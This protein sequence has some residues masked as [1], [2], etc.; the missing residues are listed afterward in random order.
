MFCVGGGK[1]KQERVQRI[2][3]IPALWQTD[4]FDSAHV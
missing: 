1:W 2:V 3:Y 4:V